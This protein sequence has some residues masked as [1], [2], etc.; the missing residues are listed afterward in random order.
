[1]DGS[2]EI[3]KSTGAVALPALAVA[4]LAVAQGGPGVSAIGPVRRRLFRR[5]A[6]YGAA[7]HVALTFDDGPAPGSTPRF[8][9]LL[10]RRG[11]HATF[12]MLGS[13]AA[14]AP[15]LAGEI[16]AAGHEVAVHGWE[17]RYLTVCGPQAAHHDIARARD[18]IAGATG[19]VPRFFRPPYGVLSGSAVVAARRLS[20][21]PLLWT[22]WGREWIPGA[23]PESVYATVTTALGGGGTILLH[24]SDAASP[25]GSAVTA[26]GALPRLL[27][28][29]ARRGLTVGT[30]AG[31]GISQAGPAERS[32]CRT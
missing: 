15:G 26:L 6:G 11:V 18:T 3:R 25:P 28:E 27:D 22:C 30:A 13:M 7:G 4:A 5:L 1:V 32:P 2:G 19:Q 9:D 12:F 24:D 10:S 16:A 8:L 23:T 31:H 29:C 20:L 21:R 14:A 17:H